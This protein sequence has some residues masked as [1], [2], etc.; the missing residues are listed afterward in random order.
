[1]F[2]SL[3]NKL[4]FPI[5][6]MLLL[7]AV[8]I[9]LSSYFSAKK[10]IEAIT[11]NDARGSLQGLGNVI[12]LIIRATEMDVRTL[13]DRDSVQNLLLGRQPEYAAPVEEQMRV[14]LDIQPFYTSMTIL[15]ERGTIV[16]SSSGSAGDSRADRDYFIG[17]FGGKLTL[18]KPSTSKSTKAPIVVIGAPVHKRNSNTP[19]G[20]AAAV[21]NLGAF[22]KRYVAPIT[23][24]SRGFAMVVDSRGIIVAH[25]D[26]NKS[27]SPYPRH[28]TRG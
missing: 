8:S 6:T 25:R 28:C 10:A 7:G 18:S 21:M 4:L 9:S 11:V 3:R 26:R 24:C 20:V 23:L 15:D 17:A 12:E 19:I 2:R 5:L 1:M 22:S 14:A 16:A 27:P 13:A